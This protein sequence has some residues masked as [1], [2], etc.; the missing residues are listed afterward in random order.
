MD[1]YPL[2]LK[3]FETRIK[4]SRSKKDQKEN[5]PTNEIT[6]ESRIDLN[7][8]QRETINNSKNLQVLRKDVARTIY[9]L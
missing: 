1:G 9:A 3:F 8:G 2:F 7:S 5:L 6:P 4:T